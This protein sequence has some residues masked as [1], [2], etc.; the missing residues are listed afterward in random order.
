MMLV[1]GCEAKRLQSPQ[2]EQ[3]PVETLP[4]PLSA[5]NIGQDDSQQTFLMLEVGPTSLTFTLPNAVLGEIGQ[6]FITL[7]ARA[8]TKPS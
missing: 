8:P 4:L 6:T 7:S 3:P 5:V 1:L 2:L